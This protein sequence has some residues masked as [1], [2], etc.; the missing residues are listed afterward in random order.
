MHDPEPAWDWKRPGLELAFAVLW[1]RTHP[2]DACTMIAN[3]KL[4][5]T[6][7]LPESSSME[8]LILASSCSELSAPYPKLEQ[9]F[10]RSGRFNVHKVSKGSHSLSS[11]HPSFE[12]PSPRYG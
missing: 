12:E 2:P 7:H 1:T 4:A 3:A 11:G 5:S 9:D 6:L 10:F 8:V